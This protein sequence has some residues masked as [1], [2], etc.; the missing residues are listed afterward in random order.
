MRIILLLHFKKVLN[1]DPKVQNA[2][3]SMKKGVKSVFRIHN[4]DEKYILAAG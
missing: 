1:P 2:S 3:F 4:P